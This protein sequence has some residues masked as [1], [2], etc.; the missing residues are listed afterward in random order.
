MQTI[1]F[2]SG[3]GVPKWL[4]KTKFVWNQSIWKNYNCIFLSSKIPISD[5]IVEQ[6]LN[7]LTNIIN[8]YPNIIVA[9]QSLGAW[10]IANL[11]YRVKFNKLI[12]WTP[13]GDIN[14]YPIFN[15]SAK[16]NLLNYQSQHHNIGPQNT[17]LFKS[18]NDLIVPAEDHSYIFENQF[19][20]MTYTLEGGHFFQ[21]NHQAA[22]NYMRDWIEI[23]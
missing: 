9:G 15:V 17:L 10:W 1:V 12:L 14:Y 6:E 23:I 16:Y 18:T 3:L 5:T 8:L 11:S 4:A 22:L 21:S 13:L 7:Y 2:L 19:N 20:P